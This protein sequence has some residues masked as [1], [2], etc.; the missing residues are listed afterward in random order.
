MKR[1]DIRY[2]KHLSALKLYAG[3]ID[4]L[5]GPMTIDGIKKFQTMNGL[6]SD[7]IVGPKT[8]KAFEGSLSVVGDRNIPNPKIEINPDVSWP[9]ETMSE[10]QKFYGKVGTNQVRLTTPYPMVLAWDK[11]VTIKSIMCHSLV[12]KSLG[13][14]LENVADIYTEEEITKHGF[15]L[16]GG[17]L[18]VRKIRGGNRWSTHAWGIAIDFDPA[19]NGLRT[20]WKDAYLSKPECAGFVQA[21]ENESWYS[22]GRKKD[23]D[24]MHFQCAYR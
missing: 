10:L 19:R 21:F 8:R 12:S 5:M 4:G 1:I 17:C 18:N 22:L 15:N 23:Y 2:Q 20:K 9:R 6:K 24:A 11:K 3:Q 14:V 13:R 7:G 16:F